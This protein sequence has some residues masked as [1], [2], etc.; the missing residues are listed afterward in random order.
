MNDWI[1]NNQAN[2]EA[3]VI[4]PEHVQLRFQTAGLGSRAAA[5]LIDTAILLLVNITLFIVFSIVV[6]GSDEQAWSDLE[7]FAI[8]ILLF[9]LFLI[10]AGYFFILEAF[11]SG[12]TLGKRWMKL[13]VIRENGQPITFLSAAIRNLFR[14][15]DVLPS[16]YFLGAMVSFFHPKDKRIGDLVAG[17][18]VV[19]EGGQNVPPSRKQ[20]AQQK[21]GVGAPLLLDDRQKQAITREDWQLLSTFVT[22][23]DSLS[24]E[25]Q[26]ELGTQIAERF[27]EKLEWNE[28]EQVEAD[29]IVFLQRLY[30]ELRK[31]WQL[32]K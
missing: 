22:R 5:Q 29:P 2:R 20:K 15:I 10:N 23:L 8:A 25:K 3:T 19:A 17:T 7:D 32:G 6:Y 4:T 27:I 28:G 9:V 14:I 1:Q 12:Q 31:E 13:R 26:K 11:W 16:G 21:E 24:S 18:I 30:W